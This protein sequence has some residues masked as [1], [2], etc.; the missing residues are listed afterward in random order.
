MKTIIL[1]IVAT[2]FFAGSA[3]AQPTFFYLSQVTVSPPN[4]APGQEICFH[5]SGTKSTPC[6][7]EEIFEVTPLG[8]NNLLLDMCFNDTS[9]CIQILWPWDSTLCIPGLPAGDYVLKFG[10]CNHDGIGQTLEFTVSGAAAPQSQFSADPEQGCAPLE[11]AFLN[12]SVNADQYLW[13]FGDGTTSTGENPVHTFLE[14]GSYS[15]TLTATNSSTGQSDSF[16]S[17]LVVFPDPTVDIGPDTTITTSQ[18]LTLNAGPGFAGYLWQDGSTTA[19][20]QIDGSQLSPGVY[21]YSVTVTNAQG[22]E[23]TD[24]VVITITDPSGVE[25]TPLFPAFRV[26]PNPAS[27]VLHMETE[28]LILQVQWLDLT[29]RVIY[30]GPPVSKTQIR[31]PDLANGIYLL[32]AISEGYSYGVLVEVIR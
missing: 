25:E 7:Y 12:Q 18:N 16:S 9:I 22:C 1:L 29:G 13:D 27:Q 21:T 20:L 8:G 6:V 17:T 26:Y 28:A 11:V 4:P 14:T 2:I 3:P 31:V 5:V 32:R 24:E 15:I 23:G 30:Q 19:F 10:G